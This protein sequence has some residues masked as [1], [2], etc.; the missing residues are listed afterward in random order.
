MPALWL[1]RLPLPNLPAYTAIS[2]CLLLCSVYFA[3]TTQDRL[4]EEAV[5]RLAYAE[6]MQRRCLPLSHLNSSSSEQRTSLGDY[7][8][9]LVTYPTPRALQQQFLKHKLRSDF[10]YWPTPAAAPSSDWAEN[11]ARGP[12]DSQSL[13]YGPTIYCRDARAWASELP[14]PG[15]QE[16][17]VKTLAFMIHEPLCVWV[18]CVTRGVTRDLFHGGG[19]AIVAVPTFNGADWKLR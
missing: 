12:E 6:A 18:S 2:V 11:D 9:F 10:L 19:V 13:F 3:V 5:S 15:I 4:E 7:F 17:L 8:R 1:D 14:T 16:N